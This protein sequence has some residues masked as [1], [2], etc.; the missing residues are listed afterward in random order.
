MW[1]DQMSLLYVQTNNS[2][3]V[4]GGTKFEHCILIFMLFL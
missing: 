1:F 2:C 4:M 3:M